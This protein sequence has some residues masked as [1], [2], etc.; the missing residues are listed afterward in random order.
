MASARAV[1][2]DGSIV[3]IVPFSQDHAAESQPTG[4]PAGSPRAEIERASRRVPGGATGRRA[5]RRRRSS[6]PSTSTTSRV[7]RRTPTSSSLPTGEPVLLVRKTLERA[8]AESP[9]ER[10]EP[11]RS[12]RDLAG[13]AGRG[14]R[15]ERP[16][17]A[18]SS[19]C[20]RPPATSTTRAA[21]GAT[22]SPTA[23][24]MLR[25]LRAVKS[26]WE[27]ERI[28]EAGAMLAGVGRLRRRR[29][30]RGD[31]RDR[32]RRR[33]RGLAAASGAPGN[34]ADA[35]LR[36]RGSLRHHRGR[37]DRG[38]VGRNRHAARRARPEPLRRPRAP[39]PGRSAAASP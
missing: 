39:P 22:S 16:A 23:R 4:G 34:P 8:R 13:G 26:A 38:R 11:L 12:L 6:S 17:R 15:R 32:A 29:P 3:R 35:C 37:A 27:L 19:T 9:L 2:S 24:A 31:D 18:S 20:C 30:P 7:R 28:R 33:R 21:A 14:R 5:R 25:R 10:I 36:R 1:G